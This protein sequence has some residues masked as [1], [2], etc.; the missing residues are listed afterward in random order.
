MTIPQPHP[1]PE[2][3]D[4]EAL[5]SRMAAGREM[6]LAGLIALYGRRLTLFATRFL[7]SAA[8]A[9]E[10]VQDTFLQAWRQADRFDPGRGSVAAWLWRIATSRA[11][12]R[13]R[14]VR[15]RRFLG[16]GTAA[17]D[18]AEVLADPS[19]TAARSLAGRQRLAKVR[20]GLLQ[21]PDR[22][23]MALLLAAVE[24]LE[25]AEIAAILGASTGAVEQLLV[26]ARAAMR[27]RLPDV[28]LEIAE[29]EHG[30]D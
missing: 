17:D 21:L 28:V 29:G 14:R 5:V 2:A 4:P 18:L 1:D 16:I 23:R 27:A 9:D 26:R 30:W 3:P 13:Q 24:G 20:M 12:D 8:E 22:Q 7:G 25:T 6:A 10:V 19:P 15:V 11:I